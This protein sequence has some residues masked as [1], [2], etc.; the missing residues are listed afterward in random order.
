MTALFMLVW[1]GARVGQVVKK[2]RD[3]NCLY[4][5]ICL[6]LFVREHISL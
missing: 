2:N 6:Y 3:T 5:M 1:K 4:L